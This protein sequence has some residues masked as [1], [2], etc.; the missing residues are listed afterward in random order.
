MEDFETVK[1]E[2]ATP[3][4][5][6]P[7]VIVPTVATDSVDAKLKELG[8]SEELIPK[9]KALGVETPND[10]GYLNA[11][12]LSAVGM[13]P[14]K[15][16]KLLEALGK[17]KPAATVAKPPAATAVNTMSLDA[18]LPAALS[19]DSW[20]TALKVGGISKVDQSTVISAIRAALAHR[21][22]LYEI[23]DKLIVL[24]EAFAEQSEEPVP[25]DFFKIRKQITRR[26]YAEIFEAIDDLDSNYVTT[27]RK[28]A[29]LGK[30]DRYLWPAIIE[31]NERLKAWQDAWLKTT[32][33][34]MF[35]MGQMGAAINQG[36][37]MP[38]A[39]LTP[40]DVSPL[41][42]GAEA[43]ANAINKVFAGTGVPIAAALAYDA[44]NIKQTLM[45]D[46]LPA[47]VGAP[48]RDQMLRM[49]DAAV[50]A[51]YPR[52][53]INITRFVLAIMQ[54]KDVPA[55]NEELQYF[56][57]LYALGTQISWEQV[58]GSIPKGPT[59]IGDGKKK[60]ATY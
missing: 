37:A 34:P 9:I 6:L 1:K 17:L 41:R 25:R 5:A 22:G 13:Q 24:I 46:A 40:P 47:M 8:V 43:V 56:N 27:V 18:I 55:G 57:A 16:D 45:N 32:M 49:L 53:E 10:L 59:G 35:F 12:R 58:M 38:S 7:M 19:D 2:P 23:P 11:E 30:I 20:L 4:S 3:E 26:T 29:L 52:M 31:F 51:T 50:P 33:N 14:I 44:L 21:A 48:N 15:A 28:K 60:N 39:A 54:I 36:G 42:D